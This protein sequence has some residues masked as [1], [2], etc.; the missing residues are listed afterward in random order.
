VDVEGTL[1]RL[2]LGEHGLR[3]EDLKKAREIAALLPEIER[4]GTRGL[5]V[6]AAAGH[7]YVGLLAVELLG[8]DEVVVL[9]R[10]PAR[11]ARSREAAARLSRPARVE[12]RQAEVHERSCYSMEPHL[13]VALHACGQASD[14]VIDA[15]VD[16]RARWIL[17]VPC[18]YL[19]ASPSLEA[20]ADR[21][22]ISR[23]AEVRRRFVQA[24]IDSARTLRLEAAGYEVT[25]TAF[26]SPTVT[27]H[28]LLWRARRVCEPRRMQQ[29]AEQLARLKASART[30]GGT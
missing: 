2:Y 18:C 19:Q 29:A 13:V 6:D 7:A 23:Q 11:V 3:K 5:I 30:D 17:V 12:V 9:E 15:A 14:D 28:N 10:D 25:V 20:A 8:A 1:Q 27:P 16:V 4:I 24:L 26:V 21:L 22:G